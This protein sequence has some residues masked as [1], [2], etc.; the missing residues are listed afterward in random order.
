MS[1]TL[2]LNLCRKKLHALRSRLDARAPRLRDE[3]FHGAGGE[4]AGDLSNTPI[5]LADRGSQETEAVVNFALAENESALR[6]EIEEALLRFDN[7]TFGICEECRSEIGL[8]R[9]EAV[10]YARLCIRCAKKGQ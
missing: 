5:H 10:P 9:L 7:G 2:N 3:A 6:Q 1:R 8:D 4:S